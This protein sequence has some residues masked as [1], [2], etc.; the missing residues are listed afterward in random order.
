MVMAVRIRDSVLLDFARTDKNGQFEIGGFP[1]DTFELSIK[2]PSFDEKTYYMFGNDDNMDINIPSIVLPSKSQE[3]EEVVIYAY[4][5]PIYYKGDTLVYVADSFQVA[6]GAVV[7]DLL[8]K[9]PGI[10]VDKDGKIISQ[11][12]EISKV[13]VDGDEFFGDDPT[14]ATKNLGA[15]GIDEV[16]IYEKENDEGI[17]GDDEKIQVLDL[18]LKD[19]AKKGYFGRISG[20]SDFALTPIDGEIGTN[21]FYEG[22]LLLN[23]FSGSQKIS[24]FALGTNTPRTNFGW[25]DMRKFGLENEQTTGNRWDPG[26]SDN[27]SGVPR[28]LNA[29]VYFSDKFGKKKQT[30]L[31]FNYSFYDN[32]LDASSASRSEYFLTDSSYVTDDSTR[33]LTISQS[34][35]INLDFETK[36][37]SLTTFQIKPTVRF[38]SQRLDNTDVSDFFS[39]STSDAR[40]LGTFIN[41]TS[42]SKGYSV[43]GFARINRKFMKPKR[44]LELRYDMSL[45][46]NKTDGKL[47]STS[48]Y[49]SILLPTDSLDQENVN[50]NSSLNHYGTLTYIEPIG[51]RMKLEFEYLF[52]SGT[53]DQDKRTYDRNL[54]T[55]MYDV[56]NDSLSNIFDNTRLQNR[57]G[58]KWRYESSK[59]TV[60]VGARFRNIN[61]NNVN[62]IQDTTINQS[63]NNFLP[64]FRY[65]FKP[66]M[67]KRFNID[68][69]TSSQAPAI[70]DLAPV[71]NISD[72]NRIQV[73]NPDL[74]PNYTHN[75]NIN[76]NTWS[77]LSGRYVYAGLNGSLTDDAF[78]TATEYDVFGRTV[79]K[80]VNVDGNGFAVLYAGAGIPLWKNKVTLRPELNA[81]Y[82]RNKNF[83]FNQEN[84]TNSY[85]ITPGLD[86]DFTFFNDSLEF[87]LEASYSAN[88]AI[89]TL[90]PDGTPYSI[91]NYGAWFEWRLPLGFTIGADGT[92]TR[93]DQPGEGFYDTQF[94]V[95]NAE[96][97]KKFLKT[98]NLIVSIMGNDILNQNINARREVNGNIIT[99]YRTTIISRYFLLKLTLRFNNRK[100]TEDEFRWH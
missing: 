75:L 19:D 37:D 56:F 80:T 85:G 99:D 100:T 18:K 27:T 55:G 98:Q 70:S 14:I 10:D 81:T 50:N 5:D 13:L 33:D 92:L 16:Q 45:D 79:S 4:K 71:P 53:S 30:R 91:G 78:S 46:D 12:Q 69:R 89:S 35:R 88:N 48:E 96:V 40:S 87:G 32:Y 57:G 61:I 74:V 66:S 68:Y 44:E 42:D 67:S 47:L 84:I 36:F 2:H 93:N 26:A 63:I 43:S 58:L 77:A 64:N 62:R 17:G 60:S 94:F 38:D 86:V 28:T 6:E 1:K 34:H 65:A 3:L 31:G 9:L 73:G 54:T 23:R 49:F 95:L 25:G 97:S 76:F 59:H 8:K 90:S 15:D 83:I 20:A 29:G 11:G 39:S 41:N 51:K 21:P 22:E 52:Q 82:F 7:E 24:V 72:P